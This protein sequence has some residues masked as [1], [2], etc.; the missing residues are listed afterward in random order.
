MNISCENTHRPDR[1]PAR[2]R[3]SVLAITGAALL[4]FV[5]T[6]TM[7]QDSAD[8]GIEEIVVTSSKRGAQLL[9]SVPAAIQAVTGE[10][11]ENMGIADFTGIAGQI[12][13]LVYQDLGPGDREYVI[14]GINST[15]AATVGVYYD[16]TVITARNKQDG[17]GRQADIKLYDL[18]RIEI[19]KGPQGTLYGAS[20]MSGTIRLITRK[21]DPTQFEGRIEGEFSGAGS[22]RL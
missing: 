12:P 13:S 9:Q 11:L 19:L 14:R 15:G 7:A 21:P 3:I 22:F 1:S 17:G 5:A 20:S 8:F 16:E 4:A 10:T 6:E 2:Y 18:E